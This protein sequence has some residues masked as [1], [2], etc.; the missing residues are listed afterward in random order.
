MNNKVQNRRSQ[1]LGESSNYHGKEREIFGITFFGSNL[2]QLLNELYRR[3]RAKEKNIWIT[4]INPEF[5]MLMSN[6]EEFTDIINKSNIKVI[7]GI[8][9]IWA[10]NV[11]RYKRG[12]GRWWQGVRIGREI[13]G[14]KRRQELISG[15]DLM[16]EICN[17]GN[18]KIYFLGGWGDR[19]K[20]TADYFKSKNEKLETRYSSGEP[21]VDNETVI[22]EINKF[23][24]DF[25][26][27]AYGMKKQEEWIAANIKRLRVGVVM[28][29]GR[30]FDYYSGDLKRAPVFIRKMGLEWLYSLFK[31]PKRWKRQLVLPK[32]VWMVLTKIA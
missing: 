9:L 29:I 32:F 30:S 27:V 5:I 22:K 2:N 20:R 24:P 10:Y 12:F 17:K 15:S 13:L 18:S 23:Q 8:G 16:R 1:V 14:G 6:D 7:D 28:G 4:T 3:I 25:L 31:E 26:F 11:L 21:E 19:A